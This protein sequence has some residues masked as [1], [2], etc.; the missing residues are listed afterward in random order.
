MAVWPVF[1]AQVRRQTLCYQGAEIAV[2][3]TQLLGS[4]KFMSVSYGGVGSC[5]GQCTKTLVFFSCK[6]CFLIGNNTV[7]FHCVTGLVDITRSKCSCL[8]GIRVPWVYCEEAVNSKMRR[9]LWILQYDKIPGKN[10]RLFGS[11]WIFLYVLETV[12]WDNLVMVYFLSNSLRR[13]LGTFLNSFCHFCRNKLS[14]F[15]FFSQH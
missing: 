13:L 3:W 4:N 15:S 1:C 5:F 9:N 8:I 11:R 12:Q 10:L 7:L 14:H 2:D 6:G